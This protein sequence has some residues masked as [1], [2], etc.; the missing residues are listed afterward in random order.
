[1]VELK[2]YTSFTALKSEEKPGAIDPSD[3]TAF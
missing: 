1:M 2:R 3:G